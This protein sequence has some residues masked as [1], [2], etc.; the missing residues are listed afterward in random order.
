MDESQVIDNNLVVGWAIATAYSDSVT[1]KHLLETNW[2]PFAYA[3]KTYHFK[4][5]IW[6]VASPAEEP[7]SA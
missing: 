6:C 3:D 2:E 5:Q 1:M 4:K 7:K